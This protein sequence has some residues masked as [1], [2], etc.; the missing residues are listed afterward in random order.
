MISL[1]T[2]MAGRIMMYTA[3]ANRT[4]K[5]AGR[6]WGRRRGPV[7]KAEME[8]ALEAGKQQ[9]DGDDRVPRTMTRLVA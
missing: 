5:G 2:P 6:G 4:R 7:K 3:D 8:H 9:G 1:I